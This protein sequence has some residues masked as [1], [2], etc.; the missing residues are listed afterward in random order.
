M[1]TDA[2]SLPP[3]SRF[4][5][6]WHSLFELDFFP[7]TVKDPQMVFTFRLLRDYQLKLLQSGI[8]PFAYIKALRRQT[9]NVFTGNVPDPYKQFMFVTQLWPFFEAEKR[10]GHVHGIDKV[11]RGR[12]PGNLVV[13]CPTCPDPTNME[14]GW[15]RTPHE[16][17]HLHQTHLTLDG[18]FQANHYSKNCNPNDVSLWGGRSYIPLDSVYK[19]HIQQAGSDFQN[20][21][22][23][24]GHTIKAIEKQNRVKFKNMDISGIVNCQCDHIFVW[25][26]VDLQLGE[27]FVNTDYVLRLALELHDFH[28]SKDTASYDKT[29]VPNAGQYQQPCGC[30]CTCTPDH[31]CSYDSMCS[32]CKKITQ[33]WRKHHPEFIPIIEKMRWV[34]PTCHCC[35]H[36]EGCDYLYSSAFKPCTA[37]FHAETAEYYWPNL[38]AIAPA[39]RQM[40]PGRRHDTIIQ[41]HGDWNWRKVVATARQLLKEL[42]EAKKKY[43]QKRDHFIGLCELYAHRVVEW[44]AVDRSPRVNPKNKRQVL[45]VYSHNNDDKMPSLNALVDFMQQS[46]ELLETAESKVHIGKAAVFL[47]E[48]MALLQLQAR[49]ARIAASEDTTTSHLKEVVSRREKLST[50]IGKWRKDQ[51]RLMP[52]IARDVAQQPPGPPEQE[53]LF[54]PSHFAADKRLEYK[55]VSLASRQATL[56]EGGL[57]DVIQALQTTVQIL[58]AAYDRKKKNDRGQDANTRSLTDLLA[59]ESKR[60]GFIQDYS[61]LRNALADLDLLDPKV[62]P[63]MEVRDTFRKSSEQRR[64][65]GDSQVE[66]GILWHMGVPELRQRI[67]EEDEEVLGCDGNDEVACDIEVGVSY[68]GTQMSHRRGQAA[69]GPVKKR[70]EDPQQK[71]KSSKKQDKDDERGVTTDGWIWHA[72]GMGKMTEEQI[73]RWA[74]TCDWVQWMRSE[75]DFERWQEQ[76]ERK[77]AEF[78]RCIAFFANARDTWRTLASDEHSST[79]GHRAYAKEHSDMYETL[80]LDCEIKYKACAIPI[81]HNIPSGKTLADQVLCFRQTENKYFTFDRATRPAFRDPTCHATGFGDVREEEIG[82]KR[83]RDGEE[84]DDDA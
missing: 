66:E 22:C 37:H 70:K 61:L 78:M 36:V 33:R 56:L 1:A 49:V 21:K 20:E 45:S 64:T 51:K 42:V 27:R 19:A 15:E 55:L 43:I 32:F 25:S 77:H 28:H 46:P 11:Q 29:H 52:L 31:V 26:S 12:R 68:S 75:A 58:T 57:N 3:R 60:D 24:C 44:N 73:K 63:T 2:P 67:T 18:N 30:P 38:N 41:N 48:G 74:D 81:L 83:K 14:P 10:F 16:L 8:T 5:N 34:I 53:K 62:W 23:L 54:L 65:P 84:S 82:A 69:R 47:K 13:Y 76:L 40:N 79:P 4:F 71:A 9:D 6:K 80:R 35:N 72:R 7:A 39:L 59:I 50:R 17:R